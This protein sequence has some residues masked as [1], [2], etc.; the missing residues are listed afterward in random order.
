MKL[1]FS[2]DA[3]DAS[4]AEAWRLRADGESWRRCVFA[5]DL[6]EGDARLTDLE[7]VS[8]WAGRRLR[9][10]RARGLV[11]KDKPGMFDFLMRGIFAHAVVHRFSPP[12]I[13]DKSQMLAAL[14]DAKPGVP[15]LL[16]LDL[17]GH[18]RLLDTSRQKIL[19]NLEI[20][21]RGEIA[22]SPAYVGSQAVEDDRRMQEL[23]RQFLGGWLQHLKSRRLAVFVPAVEETESEEKLRRAIEQWRWETPPGP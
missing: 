2:I 22:S 14:R 8:D 19:G 23:Y 3:V 20:A 13:P 11:P 16:Y 7:E 6:K 10:D 4:G 15:W 5:E 1:A 21:V 9:R 12:P 18:F 17:A